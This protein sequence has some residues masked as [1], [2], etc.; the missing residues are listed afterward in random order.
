MNMNKRLA[1]LALIG[2]L[3]F[4]GGNGFLQAQIISVTDTT[5]TPIPGEGHSYIQMLNETVNPANGSVSLR[6]QLPTPQSRG[7]TIPFGFAYD[8]TGAH[9]PGGSIAGEAG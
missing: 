2:T 6:L 4:F 9:F 1:H 5:S 7:L 8:S 3:A